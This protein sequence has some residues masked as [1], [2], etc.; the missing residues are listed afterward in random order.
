M[1][2]EGDAERLVVLLEARLNDFE[3]NMLKAAGI[4]TKNFNA[5]KKGSKGAADAME[6]DMRRSTSRINEMLAS[7]SSKMGA[8]GKGLVGGIAGGLG[9]AGLNGLVST[10]GKV[11]NSIATIGDEAKRAGL[12]TKTFQ[13]LKYVAEQSRVGVDSLVDGIKELNLRADEWIVTG[14]GPAAEAF[15]RLGYSAGE[16]KEKLKDPSA[17]FTEIIGKLEKLDRAAQIRIADEVFGGTGGEKF[18]QLI[19][20]GEKGIRKQIQAANDLGIVLDQEVIDKAAEVDRLFSQ[21]SATI[22]GWVQPAVITFLKDVLG[23]MEMVKSQENR[24][25][26]TL[27]AELADLGKQRLEL[28]RRRIDIG[29]RQARGDRGMGD[30]ILG[31]GE[32]DFGTAIQELERENEA[33]AEN[34]RR[35]LAVIAARDKAAVAPP[36]GR[37]QTTGGP[38]RYLGGQVTLPNATNIIPER[39]VD[40]YFAEPDSSSSAKIGDNIATAFIKKFEGFI[41]KSQWDV[42]AYRAGYGSDTTTRANGSV[43]RVTASTVVSLEDANRD[44]ARR[45]AEFQAVVSQQLGPDTFASFSEEQQAALTSIAYNYGSLPD[46][47]VQAILTG[48]PGAVGQAIAGLGSDNGG[49]NKDRRAQEADLFSSGSSSAYFDKIRTETDAVKTA[50]EELQASYD[51]LGQIGMTALEGIANALADGKIE[52]KELLQILMS[53]LKQLLAMPAI[54]G[55][56]AG[57]AAGGG[58]L[59]SIL[60][61]IPKLFGFAD[62]TDFAPGGLARI[63]ERGGEIVDLP[64]GSRVIPHDVSMQMAKSASTQSQFSPVFNVDARG[65]TMSAAQFEAIASRQSQQALAAYDEQQKRGGASSSA[66]RYNSLKG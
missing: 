3:K 7:T 16:L 57:G 31:F 64:R 21:V 41:A 28:E 53:V 45:I 37:L 33:L 34:E 23:L 58:G 13:E 36:V 1:A 24:Q 20:Q 55:G 65:S 10:L 35:I 60:G 29:E 8:F 17:L 4:S 51:Q 44:L 30:G 18:V 27:E 66:K 19:E 61:L 15:T 42:N 25:S 14:A 5:I 48:D 2:G 26:S 56:A 47:I 9:V 52:G 43:E 49:I 22:G 39:R 62:G 54:S 6:G 46:R 40:P 12:S 38:A 63:N 32:T 50:N 59:G 11:A